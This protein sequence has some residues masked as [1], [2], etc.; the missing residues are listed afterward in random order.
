MAIKAFLP[1]LKFYQVILILSQ[2][3]LNSCLIF[4]GSIVSSLRIGVPG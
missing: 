1:T 2:V 3:P 4:E